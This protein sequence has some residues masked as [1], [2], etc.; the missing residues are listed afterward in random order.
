MYIEDLVFGGY[1]VMVSIGV[2]IISLLEADS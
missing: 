1:L 2:I